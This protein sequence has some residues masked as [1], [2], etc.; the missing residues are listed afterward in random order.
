M[1]GYARRGC[2]HIA[3]AA[4]L[5]ATAL[6][7]ASVAFAVPRHLA[8]QPFPDAHEYADSARQL[9]KGHGY[10]TLVH[11]GE[12]LPPRYPPGF[13]LALAPFATFD[14]FPDNVQRGAKVF[15]LLYVLM[16]VAAAWTLGGPVAA[17]IA[18]ALVG[19]S[20]FARESGTLVMSDALAAALTT[21]LLLV[22]RSATRAGSALGGLLAG[23]LVVIRTTAIAALVGLV[24]AVPRRTALRV[25][26]F[27]APPIAALALLQWLTFGDP[28]TTGYTYW[29]YD[30]GAFTLGHATVDP[31]RGDGPF[32]VGDRLHGRL[33][34]W[35]C[36]CLPGGPEASMPNVLFYPFV[37]LGMFWIYAPPLATLPGLVYAFVR[38]REP[39]SR[40]VLA[41]TTMTLLAYMFFFYQGSRFMAPPSTLLVVLSSVALARVGERGTHTLVAPGGLSRLRGRGGARRWRG[42]RPAT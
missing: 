10:V 16:A 13:A 24:A 2:R 7:L 20:P 12:P 29:G 41:V 15:A 35:T 31:P 11:G 9:T 32:V 28:L 36:P 14:D 30:E 8:T 21:A 27:A 25:L 34:D 33:A 22:V 40:F 23:L 38:W 18:A 19:L 37:L 4:A 42:S 26:L 3:T 6:T 1:S 17:L 39:E 5:V